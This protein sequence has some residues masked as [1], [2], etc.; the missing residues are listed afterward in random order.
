MKQ[1][2]LEARIKNIIEYDGL[3]FKDLNN[4]GKLD[5]YEDWRLSPRERAENLVS[6]KKK[7]L[8]VHN[9]KHF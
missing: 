5:P 1:P 6:L 7:M 9:T 3:K 2:N 8:S 4:N